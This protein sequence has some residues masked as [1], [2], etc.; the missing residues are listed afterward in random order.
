MILTARVGSAD[1]FAGYREGGAD[2]YLS[3][4]VA[5]DEL[6]LVLQG[7]GRRI[8]HPESAR[9]RTLSLRERTLTGPSPGQRFRLTHREKVLLIELI[10]ARDNAVG[11]ALLCQLF[12]DED[13]G[14]EINKHAL[15]ELVARLRRKFKAVQPERAEPAIKSICGFG[16]QLCIQV[17]LR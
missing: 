3:K 16:H 5:P 14:V 8:R 6:V 2:V 17:L 9:G 1:R 12:T 11:S 15:E 7:L 13:G 4:P 10:Q